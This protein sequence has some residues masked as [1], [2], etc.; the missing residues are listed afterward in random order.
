MKK[1]RLSKPMR[2]PKITSAV[3]LTA[4]SWAAGLFL[5]PFLLRVAIRWI[6]SGLNIQLVP[7]FGGAL[8]NLFL[9]PAAGGAIDGLITP[10]LFRANTPGWLLTQAAAWLGLGVAGL[11]AGAIGGWVMYHVLQNGGLTPE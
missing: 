2:S 1:G 10:I 6:E 4:L 9:G 3:L 8:C 7:D 11:V 5:M